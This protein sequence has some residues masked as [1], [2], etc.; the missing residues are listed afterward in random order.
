MTTAIRKREVARRVFAH[1]FNKSTYKM[2]DES[3]KSPVYVLSP[4]GLRCNRIF[5]V[6]ALLEKEEV[7]PDSGIWRI[8]VSD[9]TGVFS[10][11][12]SRYQPEALESL[13]EIEP[14]ELVAITAKVRVF[15]GE[16]TM[17]FI[18]PE[19]ISTVTSDVRDYWV[20]E[21]ARG[22]IERIE[23]V[24]RDEDEDIKLAKQVY[25]IDLGEYKNVVKQALLTLM[26]GF[27]EVEEGVEEKEEEKEEIEEAEG[28]IE[29]FEDIDEFEFE[30]EEWDLSELLED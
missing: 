29:D 9:P 30:E 13:L 10:G 8:R 14:P 3:E 11:F 7:R 12:V 17:V 16:R 21:T 20:V 6:G 24:E 1:E 19:N 4:L 22:T 25:S 28:E 23:K 27:V 18:R 15:E 5:V 2:Q 26:E